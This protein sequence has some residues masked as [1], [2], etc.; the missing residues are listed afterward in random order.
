MKLRNRKSKKGFTMLELLTVIFILA[1][2]ASI[3]IPTIKRAMWKAQLTGCMTNI[4]NMATAIQI[5]S[6]DSDGLYPSSLD[7]LVPKYVA[8]IPT[9]PSAQTDTYTSGY[10]IQDDNQNF[11]LKCDGT[12]HAV[13]GYGEGIPYYDLFTG[14]SPR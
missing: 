6:N 14:L 1:A 10:I 12:N 9:C 7:L 2:L 3:M 13:L 4:R 8:A 11:T 5:Y